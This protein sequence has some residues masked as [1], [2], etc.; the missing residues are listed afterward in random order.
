MVLIHSPKKFRPSYIL[1]GSLCFWTAITIF[2][3]YFWEY[4][5]PRSLVSF[6]YFLSTSIVF[7]IVTY[8]E[9]Q[10]EKNRLLLTSDKYFLKLSFFAF[11]TL[12]VLL[13]FSVGLLLYDVV[14]GE[15]EYGNFA[16]TQLE[17]FFIT[18]IFK[19][20]KQLEQR[21]VDREIS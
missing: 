15:F 8:R 11:Y 16:I 12:L 1:T 13:I 14:N 19:S 17:L 20:I 18:Y 9:M 7:I 4:N 5:E 6:F 10:Q 2:G 21:L 3:I